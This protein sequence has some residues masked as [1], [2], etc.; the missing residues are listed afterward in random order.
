MVKKINIK[1]QNLIWIYILR[2]MNQ[3]IQ[4][5]TEWGLGLK[6]QKLQSLL[7]KFYTKLSYQ[8]ILWKRKFFAWYQTAAD[9]I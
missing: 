1:S 8:L 3:D 4:C 9:F 6:F 7:T 5:N 2:D